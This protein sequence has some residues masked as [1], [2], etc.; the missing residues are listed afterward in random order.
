MHSNFK[1]EEQTQWTAQS[2]LSYLLITNE[3]PKD[4]DPDHHI[5]K[6]LLLYQ[7]ISDS[8]QHRKS[9]PVSVSDLQ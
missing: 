1:N 2:T 5:I 4:Y 7:R 3:K 8:E 6:I 9:Q